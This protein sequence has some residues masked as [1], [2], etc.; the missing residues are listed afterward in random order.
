MIYELLFFRRTE[1]SK[2]CEGAGR[3]NSSGAA[4]HLD[5][6]SER[7]SDLSLRRTL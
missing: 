1:R 4:H 5:S 3:V 2:G 6:N 7:F